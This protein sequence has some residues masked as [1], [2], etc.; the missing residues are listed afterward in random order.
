MIMLSKVKDYILDQ[1]FRITLFENRL[2]AVNF[3]KILSL[4]ESKVSFLTNYGRVIV[5]GREFTLNRLLENEVL[6]GG[7]IE[8]VEVFYE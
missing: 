7:I 8:Q 1:E 5:K 2:L 3:I 4:E 6:I